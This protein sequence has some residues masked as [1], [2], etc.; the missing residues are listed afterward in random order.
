MQIQA[1]YLVDRAV[2]DETG[3]RVH[4]SIPN[5]V[6]IYTYSLRSPYSSV[7]GSEQPADSVQD[8]FIPNGNRYFSRD[9]NVGFRMIDIDSGT[10]VGRLQGATGATGWVSNFDGSRIATLGGRGNISLF[11][12]EES[13]TDNGPMPA[14]AGS[15]MRL[16]ADGSTLIVGGRTGE[17][18]HAR[19]DQVAGQTGP[20]LRRLDLPAPALQYA[21]APDG[22]SIVT[23]QADGTVAI[24]DLP[25]ST[26]DNTQTTA[27]AAPAL[28]NT[29]EIS[30]HG[31]LLTAMALSPDGGLLATASLDGRLRITNVSLAK[32]VHGLPFSALPSGP[33]RRPLEAEPLDDSPYALMGEPPASGNGGTRPFVVV[34]NA[35][36]SLGEARDARDRAAAAG[37]PDGLIYRRQGFFRGVF[38]FEAAEA[39]DAALPGI[40]EAFAGAYS[41]DLGT[42]C[43]DAVAN[44]NDDF[45]E[46]A[47][48]LAGRPTAGDGQL[49]RHPAVLNPAADPASRWCRWRAEFR[50]R[51]AAPGSRPAPCPTLCWAPRARA[52]RPRRC[53]P[54][55]PG[56]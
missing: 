25:S 14:L 54:A 46:C 7:F 2:F 4:V 51:Q 43:P 22:T 13:A 12:E 31:A 10:V 27:S 16:S 42:W 34:Y 49:R 1:P 33:E 19:L 8:D 36:T 50:R 56:W 39:R 55:S 28:A 40:Q 15:S 9:G 11:R 30:G 23:A 20:R 41:R 29:I 53:P 47:A 5:S 21:I 32:F 48:V 6:H 3:K 35:R 37:F 38:A 45:F 24:S 52:H 26:A 17:M 18:Y 44:E